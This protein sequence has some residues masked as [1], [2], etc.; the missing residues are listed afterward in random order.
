M[1]A[2]LTIMALLAIFRP[3]LPSWLPGPGPG[4]ITL[5]AVD[6]LHGLQNKIAACCCRCPGGAD[7][8][9][10]PCA[11]RTSSSTA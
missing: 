7:A 11:F 10:A 4:R 3:G 1:V 2:A 9:P 5:A 8:Y 6:R